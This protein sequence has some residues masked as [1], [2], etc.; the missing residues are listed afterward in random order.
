MHTHYVKI[1]KNINILSLQDIAAWT[2][3][4]LI[5]PHQMIAHIPPLQRGLVWEPYQIELFWD[6][7]LRGF[8]VGSLVVCEPIQSQLP[9]IKK[10]DS[11]QAETLTHHLLDGQQ[12]CNAI[13]LGFTDPFADP[14]TEG[15]IL[16]VDLDPELPKSSTRF[17]LVRLTT[18]AHPWGYSKEDSAAR[19][20][21]ANIRKALKDYG[22][23]GD[24]EEPLKPD[25]PKPKE[26]WP[27]EAKYPVPL[28]WLL[29]AVEYST[30]RDAFWG[31]IKEKCQK[32]YDR[33]WA[34]KIC[35][36]TQDCV[37][38]WE[39][40]YKGIQF[41]V[42]LR[43]VALEVPPELITSNSKQ[44]NGE[45]EYKD[46]ISNVEHLFHRLNRNGTP[47]EG[48][49]LSYSMIKAY[50]PE[51]RPPVDDI[52][53]KY[54]P[55]TRLVALGTR[56]ALA[57]ATKDRLPAKLSVSALRTI[58]RASISDVKKHDENNQI[59]DF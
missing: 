2:L 40:I 31:Q 24:N 23:R 49:E 59:R 15:A 55:A 50:L 54:M 10:S 45:E 44:E 34:K 38:V 51:L 7:V 29:R 46:N 36:M 5:T 56:A 21:A 42:Q 13:T 53:K 20:S 4:E 48:E 12:R 22:W 30:T 16:W 26:A 47:L 58:A 14:S 39:D 28:A 19:I 43:L 1:P 35:D 9:Y 17:F 52:S 18:E 32:N 57:A 33:A 3:P 25:R 11:V 37:E 6:S 8:P 41:A 27:V